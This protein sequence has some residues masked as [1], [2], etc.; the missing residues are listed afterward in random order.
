VF[1]V[2]TEP[3]EQPA[4]ALVP[5]AGGGYE[6]HGEPA[7][8][9]VEPG[10]L[11]DGDDVVDVVEL[12]QVQFLDVCFVP[13][14]H[15][16]ACVVYTHDRVVHAAGHQ[17]SEEGPR[18]RGKVVEQVEHFVAERGIEAVPPGGHRVGGLEV[19][20]PAP[21][22]A[23][24][25]LDRAGCRVIAEAFSDAALVH[26][27]AEEPTPVAAGVEYSLPARSMSIVSSIALQMNPCSSCISLS[28]AALRQ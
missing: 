14:H 2:V 17:R 19:K 4:P 27:L 1:V 23:P 10:G 12:G 20:G 7:G 5:V 22:E 11:E 18:V 24:S 28:S 26:E 13:L 25:V 21:S 8:R 9:G 16:W 6:A 15:Q 3:V